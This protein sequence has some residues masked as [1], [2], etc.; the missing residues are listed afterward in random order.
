MIQLLQGDCVSVMKIFEDELIDLVVT[1]PPYDN[2]RE[3]QGFSFDFESTALELARVLKPGGVIVWVVSD[4]TKNGCESLSSFKQAIFFVEKA[5]LNLYDTMIWQKQPLPLTHRRYEQHF[6]Y[7]FIFS[8]GIPKTFNPIMDDSIFAG[9]IR[10]LANK[11]ASLNDRNSKVYGKEGKI[12]ITKATKM[13]GNIWN[14]PVGWMQSSK[15]EIAF[16]HPAIFP[17]QLS[18]DHIKSWSNEGDLVLDPFCGSGTTLKSAMQLNRNAIGIEISPE[19]CDIARQ[20]I[21]QS[22]DLLTKEVLFRSG[23]DTAV[24][25]DF[26]TTCLEG[27]AGGGDLVV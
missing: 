18:A 2:L 14:Y 19:Y 26:R 13:R 20:R 9:Q 1:S 17:E 6:E 5:G 24:F 12:N 21:E 3:Y 25:G 4:Q 7:M 27:F 15:D 8:K 22:Q 10:P 11:S 23:M 16:Q